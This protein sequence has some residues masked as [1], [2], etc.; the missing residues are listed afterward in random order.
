MADAAPLYRDAPE[1]QEARAAGSSI[2][3]DFIA[4]ALP[5]VDDA[6]RLVA[7]DLIETT[8]TQVGSSFSEVERSQ[9]EIA[10]YADAMADMFCAYLAECVRTE[11]S[12]GRPWRPARVDVEL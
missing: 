7:A 2:I 4:E 3:L 10:I 1:T 12:R 5:H 11:Q 8:L 6:T 9:S